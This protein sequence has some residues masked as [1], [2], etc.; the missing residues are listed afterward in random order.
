MMK[1]L[2]ILSCLF[3]FQNVLM[4]EEDSV[5]QGLLA[6]S[7]AQG[8]SYEQADE[9][10]QDLAGK[11]LPDWQRAILYYDQGT[12]KLHQNLW[13]ESLVYFEKIELETVLSP[14]FLKDLLLNKTI[15]LISLANDDSIKQDPAYAI[16]KNSLLEQGLELIE[17]WKKIDCHIQTIENPSNVCTPSSLIHSIE[18]YIKEEIDS[19]KQKLDKELNIKASSDDPVESHL[20]DIIDGLKKTIELSKQLHA[21]NKPDL[22]KGVSLLKQDYEHIVEQIPLFYETV[23]QTE[24][25]QFDDSSSKKRCQKEPWPQVIPAFE[26]GRMLVAL[27]ESEIAKS[28][29]NWKNIYFFQQEQLMEFVRAYYYLKNP[30]K[31]SPESSSGQEN[32]P[33]NMDNV[34][35]L[36]LEMEAQDQAHKAPM[37]GLEDTW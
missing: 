37:K 34:L 16:R 11:A 25:K 24:K 2:A 28:E 20:V 19:S 8:H 3:C 18:T 15:A 4:S 36:I 26:N 14:F 31:P 7:L 23:I 1:F 6:I 33:K 27:I 30:P 29:P 22:E 35:R 9:I 10:F 12:L 32:T 13:K 17:Q 21:T 5:S